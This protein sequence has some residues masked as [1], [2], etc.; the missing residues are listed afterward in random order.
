MMEPGARGLGDYLKDLKAALRSMARPNRAAFAC[1]C[2]ERLFS[3]LLRDPGEF[4]AENVALVRAALDAAW[5]AAAS[6]MFASDPAVLIKGLDGLLPAN[7]EE[8]LEIPED[9]EDA[10]A[11]VAYAVEA[12]A[13]ADPDA[14]GSAA[15]RLFDTLERY[16]LNHGV[17]WPSRGADVTRM[18]QE[19]WAHPAT[20][21]EVARQQADLRV[22]RGGPIELAV[23][24][25]RSEARRAAVAPAGP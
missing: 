25:I 11:A 2:A 24:K 4:G 8:E 15:Q 5:E 13:D 9:V 16:L 10:I 19:E 22:L 3:A 14:A 20:V 7:D 18:D 23:A 6:G 1:A 17:E 21:A 12:A